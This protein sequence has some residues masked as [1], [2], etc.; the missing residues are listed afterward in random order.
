MFMIIEAGKGGNYRESD[1]R[2]INRPL[3]GKKKKASPPPAQKVIYVIV[4]R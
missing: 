4:A 3:K 2:L 1:S